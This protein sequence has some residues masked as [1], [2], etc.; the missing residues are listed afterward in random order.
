MEKGREGKGERETGGVE[1]EKKEDIQRPPRT[2]GMTIQHFVRASWKMCRAVVALKRR[3][4]TAAV[5][6]EGT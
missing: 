3:M 2:R 4:K 5:G 1:G 6:M